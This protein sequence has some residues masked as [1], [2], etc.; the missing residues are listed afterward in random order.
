MGSA[1]V[2]KIK[3]QKFRKILEVRLGMKKLTIILLGLLVV[4]V[5]GSVQAQESVTLTY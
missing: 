2:W 5:V 4:L 1:I 3:C